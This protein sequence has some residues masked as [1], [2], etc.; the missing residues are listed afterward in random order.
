MKAILPAVQEFGYLQIDDLGER[1]KEN[2][3]A[4]AAGNNDPSSDP[5]KLGLHL[6]NARPRAWWFVGQ[7]WLKLGNK[8]VVFRAIP[9]VNT[10]VFE[11]YLECAR[12]P[13]VRSHL[14]ECISI[15]WNKPPIPIENTDQL[16]TPLVVIRYLN[17]LYDL[18]QKHLRMMIAPLEANL[19]GKIRGRPLVRQTLR[20]NHAKGRVDR[21]YCRFHM[22]SIDTLPNQILAAALHRSIKYLHKMSISDQKLFDLTAFSTSALTGVT[23]RRILPIDF[24]GLHYGGFLRPYRTVHRWARLVLRLLGSDPLEENSIEKRRLELPPFAIDMNELFERYCEVVLRKVPGQRVWAGYKDQKRN[25]GSRVRVRPDF[26]VRTNRAAWIVDAKYK[27][28]WDWGEYRSDVYQI[29]AYSRHMEVL[30]QLEL[31]PGRDPR[32]N[33]LIVYP[34][35]QGSVSTGV[36][37]GLSLE[38]PENDDNAVYDFQVTVRRMPVQL[39]R[40][41]PIRVSVK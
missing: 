40:R 37:A 22:Q 34:G 20:A 4:I 15:F 30:K 11:M 35:P 19:V 5:E 17:I 26:L 3:R 29:V 33:A 14:N 28:D 12:H 2:L 23:L 7:V 6:E 10:S 18:C 27:E 36:I 41:K 21:T 9:K 16:I 38:A 1:A 24:Q 31:D 39:P 32:P 13:L 25:L 8:N